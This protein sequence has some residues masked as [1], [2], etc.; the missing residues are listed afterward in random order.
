VQAWHDEATSLVLVVVGILLLVGGATLHRAESVNIALLVLGV[1]LL[2]VGGLLSRIE[3]TI[4]LGPRGAEVPVGARTPTTE[5]LLRIEEVRE[6]AAEAVPTDEPEPRKGEKVAEAIGRAYLDL[7]PS[8]AV[9]AASVVASEASMAPTYWSGNPSRYSSE[10]ATG[11][12]NDWTSAPD[13]WTPAVFGAVAPSDYSQFLT[14]L[15]EP[16]DQFANRI[17]FG[18]NW[19]TGKNVS[20]GQNEEETGS[21]ES[22]SQEESDTSQQ[23]ITKSENENIGRNDPCWCGS[24]EKYK[25]CHGA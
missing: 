12:V 8:P 15:A 5:S 7:F 23:Q 24:G 25:K 3:G 13:P 16:R 20:E 11:P 4:K 14:R 10:W 2:T 21:E 19:P 18:T 6:K 1:G 17:L 9:L 22:P